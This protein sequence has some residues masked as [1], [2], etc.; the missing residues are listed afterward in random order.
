M[1]HRI[2]ALVLA[3]MLCLATGCATLKTPH[4]VAPGST[5][6]AS[7]FDSGTYN[8]LL[9]TKSVI[10]QTKADLS[11]NPPVFTTLATP[12]VKQA[13]NALITAYN[14]LDTAY[15]QYHNAVVAGTATQSQ[16]AAVTSATAQVHGAMTALTT[17][18]TGGQ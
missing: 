6:N 13:L 11:A 9:F 5:V 17:A 3:P 2:L 8:L 16:A 4:P 1:K 10:D 7:S 12:I 14:A 18:K 15:Q